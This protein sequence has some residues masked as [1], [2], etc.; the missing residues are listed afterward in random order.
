ME[1]GGGKGREGG[2]GM[3]K[4][5]GLTV[6]KNSYLMPHNGSISAKKRSILQVWLSNS[7]TV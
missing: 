5:E 4:G 2:K 7:K 1:V 3:G 6:M